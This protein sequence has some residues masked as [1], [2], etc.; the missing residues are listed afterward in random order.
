[1]KKQI[2]LKHIFLAFMLT[3]M[4]PLSSAFWGARK[5]FFLKGQA[6]QLSTKL[7]PTLEAT[8]TIAIKL[9]DIKDAYQSACLEADEDA[10]QKAEQ[11][12]REL[13]IEFEII[14]T[15]YSE[16]QLLGEMSE[17]SSDYCGKASQIARSII[18]GAEI[19]ELMEDISGIS[20]IA[21]SLYEDIKKYRQQ[22]SVV[23]AEKASYMVDQCRVMG[24]LSIASAMTLLVTFL[25]GVF[26]ARVV[27]RALKRIINVLTE[28]S[29]QVSLASGQV[30]SASFSLAEGS[31]EQAAGMEETSSSLEE[32][33]SMTKQNADNAQQANTL[34]SEAQKGRQ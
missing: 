31:T 22:K 9:N 33:A 16:D 14:S 7:F 28:G 11:I 4:V 27:T 26:V 21:A 6:E 20:V 24:L 3:L 29:K 18:D 13:A 15:A 2:S 32:V 23:F 17:K 30:S 34:A 25:L 12:A 8:N 1:M 5:S 10:L 19:S